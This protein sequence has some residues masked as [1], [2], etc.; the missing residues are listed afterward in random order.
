[1]LS[2]IKQISDAARAISGSDL[3]RRIDLGRMKSELASLAQ[4]L[5]ETFDRLEGAFYRQ[6]QFVAD[7][8]H[9]LRTP[10]S[11]IHTSSEVALNRLRT[12]DEYREAIETNLR[13]SRRMKSL[14]ESLL[15]LASADADALELKYDRVDLRQIANESAMM[16]APMAMQRN[17]TFQVAGESVVVSA[18]RNRI[19][20]LITNLFSNAIK[21]NRQ[22]GSVT[23]SVA[24]GDTAALVKVIDTGIGIS[25]EDQPHVFE[26]FF[27][28]DKARSRESGGCGLGLA[29]CQSIVLAHGGSISFSSEPGKGTQFTVRL[30]ICRDERP[31]STPVPVSAEGSE[32]CTNEKTPSNV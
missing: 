6:V 4:T 9:E 24:E 27:R 11:I 7:A 13:T 3:S 1:M 30:P 12:P 31:I 18:D 17:V 5:N 26:R 2:P 10:L 28:A 20:Q 19:G 29:I 21:Y 8:S 25:M 32:P 23:I 14:V 15:I 22:G 16:L